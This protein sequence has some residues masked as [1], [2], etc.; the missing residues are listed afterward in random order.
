MLLRFNKRSS[1]LTSVKF[2]TAAVAAGMRPEG[3]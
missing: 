2:R 3:S 1:T